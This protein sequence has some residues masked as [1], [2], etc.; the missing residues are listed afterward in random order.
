MGEGIVHGHRSGQYVN[1]FFIFAWENVDIAHSK[2]PNLYPNHPQYHPIDNSNSILFIFKIA[3]KYE[4]FQGIQFVCL[5]FKGK[6]F[7][8]SSTINSIPARIIL[9]PSSDE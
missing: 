7:N 9:R 5:A 6:S 8:P 4:T 3:D 2:K 1:C